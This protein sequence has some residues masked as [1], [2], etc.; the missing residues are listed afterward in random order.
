MK[1]SSAEEEVQHDGNCYVEQVEELI[2]NFP[3]ARPPQNT[4]TSCKVS[5]GVTRH[6]IDGSIVLWL[7]PGKRLEKVLQ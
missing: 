3:V 6:V 2:S 7:I 5:S 4:P 1:Y